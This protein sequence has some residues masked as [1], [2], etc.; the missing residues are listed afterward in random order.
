MRKRIEPTTVEKAIDSVAG[1]DL[2]YKKLEQQVVLK[3][4]TNRASTPTG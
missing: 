3:G 4:Q 2:V 1:F